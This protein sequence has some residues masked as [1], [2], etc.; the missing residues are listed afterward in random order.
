M[1]DILTVTYNG[2]SLE[3]LVHFFESVSKSIDGNFNKMVLVLDG[4]MSVE[5]KSLIRRYAKKINI[6]LFEQ[7]KNGLA[8]NLQYGLERCSAKYVAR[9]DTDDVMILNRFGKQYELLQENGVDLVSSGTL[10]VAP[11]FQR[12]RRFAPQIIQKSSAK[13]YFLNLVNHNCCMYSRK[14]LIKSGGYKPGRMEDFRAWIGLLND[15]CKIL[16][17]DSVLAQV[18]AINLHS[19]R[20]GMDYIRAEIKLFRINLLR[21]PPQSVLL[22]LVALLFRIPMRTKLLS[23]L[24]KLV[25]SWTRR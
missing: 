19:R 8:V 2:E 9:A 18:S 10:E 13:M 7:P 11:E 20:I 24:L 16:I 12:F 14:A 1:Y 6:S 3:N 17:D 22:A 25:H 23:P 5:K 15:D 4:E 21:F